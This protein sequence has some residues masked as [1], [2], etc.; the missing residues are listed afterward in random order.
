MTV[1]VRLDAGLYEPDATAYRAEV[2]VDRTTAGNDGGCTRRFDAASY[3]DATFRMMSS[4]PGSARNTSETGMP[5][6]GTGVGVS[7]F[8]PS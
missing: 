8:T 6:A 5:G 1:Q 3:A 7:L 4:L 2:C